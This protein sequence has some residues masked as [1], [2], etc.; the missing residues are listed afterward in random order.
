MAEP[1]AAPLQ[2]ILLR[3]TAAWPSQTLNHYVGHLGYMMEHI[4]LPK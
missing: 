4:H 3:Q 1:A 2:E